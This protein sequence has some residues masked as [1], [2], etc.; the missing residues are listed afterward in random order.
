MNTMIE[1][2]SLGKLV[3]KATLSFEQERTSD[4]STNKVTKAMHEYHTRIRLL[5]Q[6][7]I[8]SSCTVLQ[9]LYVHFSGS[10]VC[11]LPTLAEFVRLSLSFPSL[12]LTD[13]SLKLALPFN[14]CLR[15]L[16]LSAVSTR[17]QLP[18]DL[19]EWIDCMSEI[20]GLHLHK[21]Q[22][23]DDMRTSSHPQHAVVFR[24]LTAISYF[25]CNSPSQPHRRTERLEEARTIA[26]W[27]QGSPHV[28]VLNFQPSLC[29]PELLSTY[30][31]AAL[32]PFLRKLHLGLLN[33][34]D[35]LNSASLALLFDKTPALTHL[36]LDIEDAPECNLLPSLLYAATSK[37]L[38]NRLK[39]LTF[40]MCYSSYTR[41][42]FKGAEP[43]S[44]LIRTFTHLQ[45][46]TIVTTLS[47]LPELIN[48]YHASVKDESSY[49]SP[50]EVDQ[51]IAFATVKDYGQLWQVR[52]DGY[53]VN[54][55]V[56]FRGK[57]QVVDVGCLKTAS[58]GTMK[59]YSE[60]FVSFVCA[61]AN[62]DQTPPGRT[63]LPVSRDP[64]L[65]LKRFLSIAFAWSWK[66]PK[67]S[68]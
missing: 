34:H 40:N 10:G 14:Q 41:R 54:I 49:L 53:F 64:A 25:I 2:P 55:E 37:G 7:A 68:R 27:M 39:S 44:A 32:F 63:S 5:K 66:N 18:E 22:F 43:W 15:D 28:R 19:E 47:T 16:S 38:A 13:A 23:Y 20:K 45:T 65:S 8:L 36:L 56:S 3:Q 21:I 67:A 31:P 60:V 1:Q 11:T 62:V 48:M 51:R 57:E 35:C 17:Y 59:V 4:P 30:F 12:Y 50:R 26:S 42:N 9:S 6:L 52:R 33:R 58:D 61:C 24:Q 29:L 46:L